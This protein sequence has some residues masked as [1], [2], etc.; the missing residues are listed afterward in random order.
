M[1]HHRIKG[2]DLPVEEQAMLLAH[3]ARPPVDWLKDLAG[4][5]CLF[6]YE[7]P[8]VNWGPSSGERLMA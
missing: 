4:H 5:G 3:V 2:A 8:Q 7:L 6:V 1:V